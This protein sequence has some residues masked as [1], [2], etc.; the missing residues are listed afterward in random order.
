MS[1]DSID[2]NWTRQI[3]SNVYEALGPTYLL[4][5]AKAYNSIVES[6]SNDDIEPSEVAY[7]ISRTLR[8]SHIGLLNLMAT[9]K[10][11]LSQAQGD[12]LERRFCVPLLLLEKRLRQLAA[13]GI[14]PTTYESMARSP[15]SFYSLIAELDVV[16]SLSE[17]G[18]AVTVHVPTSA[19][20]TTNYDVR[21]A[22]SFATL[23]GDVKWFENWALKDN[24]EIIDALSKLLKSDIECQVDV[25]VIGDDA[26]DGIEAEIAVETLELYNV[27]M[28]AG[29]AP[30]AVMISHSEGGVIRQAYRTGYEFP[31]R[32]FVRSVTVHTD[33]P[34]RGRFFVTTNA[35]N[36]SDSDSNAA[37][38]NLQGAA[39]QVPP[40]LA[41]EDVS[42]VFIGSASPTDSS[43]V[44][45]VLFGSDNIDDSNAAIAR[46][47]GFFSPDTPEGDLVHID[48]VFFF[49][50]LFESDNRGMPCANRYVNVFMRQAAPKGRKLKCIG[51]S[52][53]ALGSTVDLSEF[54]Y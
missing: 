49:S 52:E 47:P 35:T 44:R 39:I 13:L 12:S 41:D 17:C 43:D 22:N 38:A 46:I 24:R 42:V 40:S 53:V 45:D 32:H 31:P 33:Q 2:I 23:H 50:I 21:W 16:A 11:A 29:E 10:R 27:A 6:L 14:R 54:V 7:A 25:S 36:F 28:G 26:W 51:A 30:V 5:R 19:I 4:E 34:G 1:M 3:F 9:A 37:R 20:A 15:K 8:P 48:A 18:E